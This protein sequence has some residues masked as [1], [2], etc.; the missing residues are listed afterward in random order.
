MSFYLVRNCKPDECVWLIDL[1]RATKL[2]VAN[3]DTEDAFRRQ[4]SHDPESIQVLECE[5]KLV[6]MVIFLYSPWASFIW[7]LAVYSEYQGHGFGS[8]LITRA[9]EILSSRGTGV[10]C[11]YIR[12]NNTNSRYVF[13]KNGYTEHQMDLTPV[14]KLL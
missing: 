2:L 3:L 5:G 14:E 6:G 13:A 8:T 1:L 10:S 7:H 4:L 12:T 9:E 11:G